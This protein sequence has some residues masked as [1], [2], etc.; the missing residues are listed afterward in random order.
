MD[1]KTAWKLLVYTSLVIIMFYTF[2]TDEINA[3]INAGF[4]M[5]VIYIYVI[6]NNND[7]GGKSLTT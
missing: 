2:Y 7:G 3:K 1:L 4:A 6:M 5:I